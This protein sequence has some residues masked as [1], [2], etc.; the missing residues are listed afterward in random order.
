MHNY[1]APKI[2]NKTYIYIYYIYS[3]RMSTNDVR[4]TS[5][6]CSILVK[7]R[8]IGVKTDVM[9]DR[10]T[11]LRGLVT[12]WHPSRWK[13]EK[14]H[15]FKSETRH[16]FCCC[17]RHFHKWHWNILKLGRFAYTA[18]NNTKV[19]SSN[20]KGLRLDRCRLLLWKANVVFSELN[21]PCCLYQM[22]KQVCHR[23]SFLPCP[24]FPGRDGLARAPNV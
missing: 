8:S 4:S 12:T 5:E 7:L 16:L 24:E 18:G 6:W 22:S 3:P 9:I 2:S 11:T 14:M 1:Y 23:W 17:L 10:E 21:T 15:D 13:H 19:G 20:D